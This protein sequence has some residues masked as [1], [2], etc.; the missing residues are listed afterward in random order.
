MEGRQ[1]AALGM[2]W[3]LVLAVLGWRVWRAMAGPLLYL[4]FLVPFGEFATPLLQDLTAG[5]IELGLQALDISYWRDGLEIETTAGLFHVAEA[6]AGL[7]FLIA[8]LAFGALYALTMFRSPG[9]RLVVLV[10]ALAVPVVANGLRALGIVVLAQHLGSAEAAAADHV[11]YGW[12][13]FSAIIL[14]LIFA[15]LPFRQDPRH[16]RPEVAGGR[17]PSNTGLWLSALWG[18]ALAAAG[19]AAAGALAGAAGLP[20]ELPVRL[21]VPEGC[22]ALDVGSELRCGEALVSA[23]LLVFSPRVTWRAVSAEFWRREGGDD[24]DL[25]FAVEEPDGGAIWRARVASAPGGT[26]SAM[27]AWLDGQP[28]GNGLRARLAQARNSL[29]AAGGVPVLA[30]V[31]VRPTGSDV[32]AGV[33]RTILELVLAGQGDGVGSQARALSRRAAW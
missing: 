1:L 5:M 21:A 17:P 26:A 24:T 19:P 33:L 10:L 23:R 20:R 8:A 14:L 16:D 12:G 2:L 31:T 11:I 29:G 28:A 4:V 25:N 27:A 6:C 15:G 18:L 7:R 13:F 30:L 3:V 9:R 32:P 22:V